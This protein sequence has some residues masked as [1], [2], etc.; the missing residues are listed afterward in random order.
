MSTTSYLSAVLEGLVAAEFDGSLL[1]FALVTVMMFPVSGANWATS[2][3]KD[4]SF[5]GDKEL[6]DPPTGL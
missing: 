4:E 6:G 2:G 3:L 1:R 5:D